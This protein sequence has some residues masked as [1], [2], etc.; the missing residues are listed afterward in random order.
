MADAQK[1]YYQTT[2]GSKEDISTIN[3][4]EDR[5]QEL[6]GNNMLEEDEEDDMIYDDVQGE[7]MQ[8]GIVTKCRELVWQN[9]LRW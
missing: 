3:S 8:N 2:G 7:I 5:V 4:A 9:A 1:A 6:L